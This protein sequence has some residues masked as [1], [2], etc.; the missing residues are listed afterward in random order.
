MKQGAPKKEPEDVR[1]GRTIKFSD[2]EWDQVKILA[3]LNQR[4]ISRYVRE[5]VLNKGD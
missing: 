1:K 3:E 2:K 5:K 4:N